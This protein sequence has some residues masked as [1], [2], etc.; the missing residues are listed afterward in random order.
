M[1]LEPHF[2]SSLGE[3]T[4]NQRAGPS[5]T[6]GLRILTNL[7]FFPFRKAWRRESPA[8]TAPRALPFGPL[9]DRSRSTLALI[10]LAW[11]SVSKTVK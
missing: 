11:P 8:A 7:Y 6:Q 10:Y 2:R 3:T 9:L 5:A 1:V 4:K